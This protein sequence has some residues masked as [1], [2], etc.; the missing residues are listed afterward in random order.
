MSVEPP[1]LYHS[2]SWVSNCSKP[3]LLNASSLLCI[4]HPCVV[5]G[6]TP[7]GNPQ[8]GRPP[9]SPQHAS[10]RSPKVLATAD[11]GV[12]KVANVLHEPALQEN[13]ENLQLAIIPE[14]GS[15]ALV[16][17]EVQPEAKADKLIFPSF[18]GK[19]PQPLLKDEG[20]V[21]VLFFF[22]GALLSRV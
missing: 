11:A 13:V 17:V 12:S 8:R 22:F 18:L 7:K 2:A 5:Q 15:H 21:L 19:A 10:P 16:R 6:G 14:H 20:I 4:A 1:R 9:R 3:A